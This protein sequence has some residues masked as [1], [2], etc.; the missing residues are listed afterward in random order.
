MLYI[1]DID[2]VLADVTHLLPM[3]TG[4]NKD[5]ETYYSRIGEALPIANGL[6]LAQTFFGQEADSRYIYEVLMRRQ[7]PDS[8][9]GSWFGNV[10]IPPELIP[11]FIPKGI[12]FVT[13]RSEL[14]REATKQWLSQNGISTQ[15]E[16]DVLLR[17]K[18]V[19]RRNKEKVDLEICRDEETCW[20]DTAHLHMRGN[21]DRRPAYQ[22]K[23]GIVERIHQETGVPYAE[24][25]VFEDDLQCAE[26]YE[27]L[28]CYVCHVRH[29]K[30]KS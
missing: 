13:G 23:R 14:S 26:M 19:Q 22:V 27:S 29:S 16:L 28:G 17:Q 20:G 11:S 21:T 3:I 4:E 9:L 15:S 25:T 7:S 24:M 12:H 5:Y 10:A 1:F 8:E 2:G 30:A 18:E 6:R